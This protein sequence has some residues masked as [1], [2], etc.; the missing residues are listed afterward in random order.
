M[1]GRH[2][3]DKKAKMM[4]ARRESFG[5]LDSGEFFHNSSAR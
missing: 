5:Q 4:A 3:A 2:E 1:L